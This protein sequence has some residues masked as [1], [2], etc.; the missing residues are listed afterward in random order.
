MKNAPALVH[1]VAELRSHVAQARKEH[2]LIGLVLTMGALHEGHASL[3]RKARSRCGFVVATIFVNPTQFG[4]NEDFTRYPRTLEQ[5]LA[6]CAREGV[7]VVFA[8]E[9]A[10]VYPPNFQTSVQVREV[11]RGMEGAARP[12]HFEGVATVVL[13]LFNMVQA[14]ISFFGQKDAQQARLIQQ[15]VRDLN[16]PID[17]EIVPTLREP[18]GLAMSS[19][20]RYLS[21]EQRQHATVLYRALEQIHMNILAGEDRPEDLKTEVSQL[22]AQTP[23]AVLDYVAIVDWNTLQPVTKCHGRLL[24]ALAVRFGTTRLIDNLIVQVPIAVA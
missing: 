8:P 7:D 11:S 1:T 2:D 21:P 4:P 15:M 24:V 5:D 9:A 23:G 14:D 17:I 16:V 13:K 18:D 19:R 10:E 3:M 20:N 22:I 6:L 12:G